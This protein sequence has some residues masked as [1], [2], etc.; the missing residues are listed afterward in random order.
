MQLKR[1]SIKENEF[2]NGLKTVD[3]RNL[4]QIVALF[5][6]NGA[7]KT[8]LLDCVTKKIQADSKMSENAT[9]E[10]GSMRSISRVVD[11]EIGM[12][13]R[14]FKS[15]NVKA[16]RGPKGKKI[17][18]LLDEAKGEKRKIALS[19]SQ[20][21]KRIRNIL[22]VYTKQPDKSIDLIE[23]TLGNKNLQQVK[24]T[25]RAIERET[26]LAQIRKWG[27]PNSV[28][29]GVVS[30]LESIVKSTFHRDH[31]KIED[32]TIRRE[33]ALFDEAKRIIGIMM[34]MDLNY[35]VER[36]KPLTTL[37]GRKLSLSEL[38]NGQIIILGYVGYLLSELLVRGKSDKKSTLKD[39]IVI[40]D[41]PELHL[42]PEALIQV[43][44]SMRR[45][46]GDNG[47]IWLATH[48]LCLLPHLKTNEIWTMRSGKVSSP[49]IER[50]HEAAELLV[51]S[52][53]NFEKLQMFLQEPFNW[54]AARFT[55]ECLMAPTK[56]GFQKDDPQLF[57]ISKLIREKFE[58]K[59]KIILLDYGAGK[60]RVARM[61]KEDVSAGERKNIKYVPLDIDVTYK[62]EILDAAGDMLG[63]WGFMNDIVGLNQLKDKVDVAVVCNVLH[64]I[65][66]AQWYKELTTILQ[67]LH[68]QGSLIICEDQSI[69]VGELPH[70]SGF[71]I[72]DVGELHTL[73]SLEEK[74]LC[75]WHPDDRYKDRLVCVEIR[76]EEAK[77]TEITVKKALQKLGERLKTVMKNMRAEHK[78]LTAREGRRYALYSQMFVN[79]QF[80]L[81]ELQRVT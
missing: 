2:K 61:L 50:Y 63:E 81:E 10:E 47:Q 55:A 74:P 51:G 40:M 45:I 62:E 42:H 22:S 78:E 57:Q 17:I 80:A 44:K 6:P 77:V 76:K 32:D 73:F 23:L 33:A 56:A 30:L 66:P 70:K 58:N 12:L 72:L 43:I 29:N 24:P 25:R 34:R 46:V 4:G 52:G 36:L 8:R 11:K 54:A 48:C 64:E 75:K 60:G 1:V 37:D 21:K 7:G 71:V 14:T 49:S 28:A 9:R 53:E 65:H 35:V 38:S 39:T 59:E 18:E 16:R 15:L 69:P 67:A 26:A 20:R 31:P 27:T 5:G 41:E 68:S 13:K 19:L 79:S 3:M